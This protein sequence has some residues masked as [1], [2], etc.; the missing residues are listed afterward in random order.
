MWFLKSRY[1][2]KRIKSLNE[3]EENFY[4]SH[5]HQS[6]RQLPNTGDNFISGSRLNFE[7][8]IEDIIRIS[9]QPVGR[10]S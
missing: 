10:R 6:I 7:K 2:K 9:A 8:Y 5:Q 3:K 1:F 4:T